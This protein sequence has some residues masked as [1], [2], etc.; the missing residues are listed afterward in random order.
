MNIET[1]DPQFLNAEKIDAFHRLYCS[2]FS[3]INLD[4]FT[5]DL[6]G[7]DVILHFYENGTL[8]GFTSFKFIS[9]QIEQQDVDFVYSGDTII[10]PDFWHS[11][12]IAPA[13]I[14]S[15]LE[16][17]KSTNPLYWLLICSGIRTYRLL[18][19]FWKSYT[20]KLDHTDQQLSHFANI[21]AQ[22]IYGDAHQNGIVR[23]RNPQVLQNHLSEIPEHYSENKHTQYF[24]ELN[25]GH[26]EGDELVCCC[27]ITE[28]NMTRSGLR[29]HS[30]GKSLL[31]N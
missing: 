23:L 14:Q 11:N 24:L 31:C 6:M 4:D 22:Q 3:Q 29:M 17:H 1:H 28:E 16:H 15:V 30:I 5:A 8:I 27:R 13:W 25:P 18:T 26:T 19:S 10:D 2:H 7:K 12:A 21:A 20:P 9:I